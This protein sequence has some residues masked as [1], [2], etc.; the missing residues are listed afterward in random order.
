M[1]GA[2]VMKRMIALLLAAVMTLGILA[3]CTDDNNDVIVG[4]WVPSTVTLS[5]TTVAYSELANQ[6]KEFSITFE[7]GG[8]CRLVLGGIENDGTYVFNETS[9]DIDYCSKQMKLDYSEGIITLT[10]NYNNEATSYMFTK[11]VE[12]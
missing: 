3:R 2:I 12:E 1:F 7:S 6:D 9:V 5:G 10:L 4:K 8:K 11:V